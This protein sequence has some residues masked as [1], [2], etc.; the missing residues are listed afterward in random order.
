MIFIFIKV[1]YSL[2]DFSFTVKYVVLDS[3]VHHMATNIQEEPGSN[4]RLASF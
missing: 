3:T 1:K 2:I 4:L